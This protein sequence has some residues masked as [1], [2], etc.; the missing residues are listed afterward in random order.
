MGEP[1]AHRKRWESTNNDTSEFNFFF[2][3]FSEIL[4]DTVCGHAYMDNFD[5][6]N[7]DSC[8]DAKIKILHD[9]VFDLYISSPRRSADL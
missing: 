9:A 4:I 8:T 2:C 1:P 7:F 3:I 6:K 5:L